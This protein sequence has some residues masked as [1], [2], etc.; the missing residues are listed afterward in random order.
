LN[1]AALARTAREGTGGRSRK[2]ELKAERGS[3]PTMREGVPVRT[4]LHCGW[5]YQN[6]EP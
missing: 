3:S 2:Q 5:V 6:R 4:A 1:K